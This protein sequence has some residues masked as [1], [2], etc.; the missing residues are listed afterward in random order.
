MPGRGIREGK[1]T[2]SV[3][4]IDGEIVDLRTGAVHNH[5]DPESAL[6]LAADL[7]RQALIVLDDSIDCVLCDEV[8]ATPEEHEQHME[9]I[10]DC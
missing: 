8:S 10:H 1:T 3:D 4:D 7:Q 6:D 9:E 2:W 5:M